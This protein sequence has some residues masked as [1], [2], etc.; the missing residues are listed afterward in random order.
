MTYTVF[1][2]REIVRTDDQDILFCG[3]HVRLTADA[4]KFKVGDKVVMLPSGDV[5][6]VPYKSWEVGLD[7]KH[8]YGPIW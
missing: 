6:P 5:V 1:L 4:A 2:V 8:F 3:N 7:V